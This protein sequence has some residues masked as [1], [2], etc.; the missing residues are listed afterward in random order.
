MDYC[1]GRDEENGG[2]M[3]RVMKMLCG[4][5]KAAAADRECIDAKA[6]KQQI[7]T[8]TTA[9]ARKVIEPHLST[10]VEYY[11]V[12]EP[13]EVRVR[14]KRKGSKYHRKGRYADKYS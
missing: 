10:T 12:L 3:P 9:A 2:R 1:G 4:H 13:T 7:E 8:E 6:R 11:E 14:N 5:P